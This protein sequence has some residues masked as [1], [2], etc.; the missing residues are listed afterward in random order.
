MRADKFKL[1]KKQMYLQ[2]FD[3]RVEW[4]GVRCTRL[5]SVDVHT[6]FLSEVLQNKKDCWLN[7]QQYRI[8]FAVQQCFTKSRVC[9]VATSTTIFIMSTVSIQLDQFALSFGLYQAV[10]IIIASIIPNSMSFQFKRIT[11]LCFFPM[12]Y[13]VSSFIPTPQVNHIREAAQ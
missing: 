1:I 6:Y 3:S 10:D 12:F 4:Q 2:A 5:P 9:T 7:N 11:M 8:N 13:G